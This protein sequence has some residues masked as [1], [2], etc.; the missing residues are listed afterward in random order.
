MKAVD[1]YVR[2]S[3][4]SLVLFLEDLEQIEK[5]LKENGAQSIEIRTEDY[6]FSSVAE[7][8]QHYNTQSHKPKE[9]EF[10]SYHFPIWLRFNK[11]FAEVSTTK[12][13]KCELVYDKILKDLTK[14]QRKPA[15]IYSFWVTNFFQL[16][17][18]LLPL[19]I[20]LNSFFLYLFQAIVIMWS[21]Y[22]GY[23]RLFKTSDII[24]IY[25]KL[26]VSVSTSHLINSLRILGTLVLTILGGV[27]AYC[28]TEGSPKWISNAWENFTKFF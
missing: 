11:L 19:D 18:F 13:N 27:I 23:I 3:F 4:Y 28:F 12:Y 24:P 16:I 5:T 8:S 10:S 15:I 26:Y 21:L 20:W 7:F 6:E 2:K 14:C 1:K 17:A 25:K 22:V 9:L